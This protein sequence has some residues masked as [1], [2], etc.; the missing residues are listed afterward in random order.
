MKPQDLEFA[1]LTFSIALVSLWSYSC[2]LNQ[3][4]IFCDSVCWKYEI[5][6][7]ILL[8][9]L[10]KRLPWVSWRLWTFQQCC[11]CKRLWGFLSWA[12]CILLSVKATWDY[13]VE[14]AREWK[15]VVWIIIVPTSCVF[16]YWSP[17]GGT[18]WKG[19]EGMASL[20]EVCH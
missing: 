20:K 6:I 15:I 5:C 1:L 4:C 14:E 7:L 9:I 8:G 10:F 17:V 2:L 3:Y 19:L 12:T 11:D 13:G 18:V 16:A